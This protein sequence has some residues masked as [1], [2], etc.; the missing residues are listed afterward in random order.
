MRRSRVLL[1][2]V[3]I[4]AAAG[5]SDVQRAASG[6]FAPATKGTLT[7]A[8]ELPVPGFWDGNDPASTSGGFE[9]GLARALAEKLGLRLAVRE[10][11]FSDIVAGRL[12]GADLA[13]AQVSDTARREA[14]ADLTVP[15]DESSPAA[16]ARRGT[17][18]DLV[19]LAT[20]EKQRW[21]VQAGTTL[22]RYLDDVVR[23]KQKPLLRSTTAAV[24][25]AVVDGDADVALLDLPAALVVA[26]KKGLVVPARFDHVESTVGVMPAGSRNLEAIDQQLQRLLADGTVDRLRKRWL[27]PV[28]ATQPKDVPVI[29][30]QE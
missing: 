1:A 28:F 4:L 30:A 12:D 29:V 5:C 11:P 13:L 10:V 3:L 20:A 18:D 15:Y 8:T 17:E 26:A 27:D 25:Q 19:D 14:V 24:V 21:V 9:W 2:I 23:P 22:E 16:L 7:V 6:S